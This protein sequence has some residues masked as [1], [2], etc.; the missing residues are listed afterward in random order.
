MTD[1]S[2]G[3]IGARRAGQ[4]ARVV[5]PVALPVALL[6]C[7]LVVG[8]APVPCSAA[9][10]GAAPLVLHG[11]RP[12][13]S[14]DVHP[15]IDGT[16]GAPA[17][18]VVTV[19]L[20]DGVA[21]A[22]VE[23][24]VGP[25][26]AFSVVWPA[27][28]DAGLYRLRADLEGF[29]PVFAWLVVQ[30]RGDLPLRPL[31]T[32]RPDYA[33]PLRADRSDFLAFTDRWRIAPPATALTEPGSFGPSWDPYHQ[34]LLKG[35]VPIYSRVKSKGDRDVFLVWTAV[36]DT[37]LEAEA[38]PVPA[39]ISTDRP[40]EIQFFGEDA[41]W[42]A[43]QNLF[44]SADLYQG[45]TAFRPVDWRLRATLAGNLNHVSVDENA[46]VRPD[47]REGTDRTTG[48]GALQELFAEWKLADL[49]PNYDF[50]SVRGGIQPFTSD[51]RG[52]VFSDTN[53][54][55]RLFGNYDSNRWQYNLAW[56]DRLE[57]GTNS[58]LNTFESRDQQVAVANVYRQDFPV[59][60]MT[61][62][63]S[64]HYLHDEPTVHYD[65][66]GFLVRPDPAGSATPHEIDAWYFGLAA[67]GHLGKVNVDGALYY[68]TG[69]DSLNPIAG[70]GRLP[71]VKD[72]VDI[73]AAMAALEL[74]IDRNW[75]RPKLGIFYASGDD[76]PVD[77][78][79]RG[80]DAIFEN[81]AFAGGGFSYWNRLGIG[82]AG[83]GV[84]L[85]NRGSLLPSFKSSKEEGQP[86][87]VNPGL[88]L[89]TVGVDLEV[90]PKLRM[91]ATANSL[92]FD[93]TE[94]LE[95]LLFQGDVDREI[96]WDLSLGARWRPLLNENVVVLGG[97]AA[98]LPGAGWEDIYEDDSAQYLAFTNLVL[99]F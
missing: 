62:Q 70:P 79:A 38:I 78:K 98:F 3:R 14:R 75:Y 18:T 25:E 30:P 20:G 80:F 13:F 91:V 92:R 87:F 49:S 7:L 48:R 24:P 86:N 95:L 43:N 9:V 47:V 41:L 27:A 21:S 40:G 36:S 96:G 29:E 57:K 74:S 93:T 6:A 81:P 71:G 11:G 44:L 23:A 12:L 16:V 8:G 17:G 85:V 5:R 46:V 60:G 73:G 34:N 83:T 64:V 1:S 61:S 82:L 26:G 69:E 99:T 28:L 51:F 50:L 66:N 94:T 67:F 45:D 52:F 97:V 35:D 55:V 39:G 32:E 89:G 56:F 15:T 90:T 42:I 88:L 53:L 2:R 33:E 68:V 65:R 22:S 10:G 84:T 4:G 63:A 31:L 58:G 76:D 59:L 19:T 37:L 54:G 72:S 77:R